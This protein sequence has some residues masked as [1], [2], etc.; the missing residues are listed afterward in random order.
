M[1]QP[2]VILIITDQERQFTIER[3]GFRLLVVLRD[4]RP[5]VV[6]NPEYG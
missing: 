3:D 2:H 4:G 1:T 6:D 5:A